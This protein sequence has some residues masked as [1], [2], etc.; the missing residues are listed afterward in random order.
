MKLKKLIV[1]NLWKIILGVFIVFLID[2]SYKYIKKTNFLFP[3]EID[4]ETDSIYPNSAVKIFGKTPSNNLICFD[5]KLSL[6]KWEKCYGIFNSFYIVIPKNE[7]DNISK[8]KI[9]T[10]SS[11]FNLCKK[12]FKPEIK[13]IR[14]LICLNLPV[15][16]ERFVSLNMVKRVWYVYS[17]FFSKIS[18]LGAIAL[19]LILFLFYLS[20]RIES[21][22]YFKLTILTTICYCLLLVIFVIYKG[23]IYH[24][25]SALYINFW[26]YRPMLY[27][28]YI[29][30]MTHIPGAY[31]LIP[32]FNICMA[33]IPFWALVQ[34]LIKKY[35]LNN[36]FL[37]VLI[38]VLS[39][40]Y[41]DSQLLTANFL[42]AESLSYPLFIFT[43]YYIIKMFEYD[44]SK[45]YIFRFILTFSL[46][47]FTRGQFAFIYPVICLIFLHL[48]IN[49]H[50]NKYIFLFSFIASIMLQQIMDRS[51]HWVVNNRFE[52][53]SLGCVVMSGAAL[54]VSKDSDTTGLYGNKK[55]IFKDISAYLN[56]NHLRMCFAESTKE[57]DIFIHYYDSFDPIIFGNSLTNSNKMIFLYKL[58]KQNKVII[59]KND[60]YLRV[61]AQNQPLLIFNGL[62]IKTNTSLLKLL[63]SD[64]YNKTNIYNFI[65]KKNNLSFVEANNLLFSL[66]IHSIIR[67]LKK[68]LL[69]AYY[70]LKCGHYSKYAHIEYLI[71][72][73]IFFISFITYRF[74][75]NKRTYLYIAIASLLHISNLTMVS[76]IVI[77]RLRYIF[78][79]K[80]LILLLLFIVAG[81]IFFYLN[82]YRKGFLK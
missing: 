78:Y 76:F 30:V 77:M 35:S 1:L 39:Y 6:Y 13:T 49:K 26:V 60:T 54:Y 82:E 62:K 33:I 34:L 21:K 51:Y 71:S 80:A 2:F 70:N 63:Y 11:E 4:I 15:K 74:R 14:H 75:E 3:I 79:T 5:E 81:K 20:K 25:D 66:S 53:T 40:P 65:N 32:F 28:L 16:D 38:M 45:K 29:N 52:S 7:I 42:I 22:K 41:I 27:P 50:P 72:I 43:C 12:H 9:N 58:M 23:A 57:K 67:N 46:L 19:I 56:K 64:K 24:P 59:E 18:L 73:I 10:S 37:P 36:L 61:Y 8:I 17:R 31:H 55:E 44:F 68:Y 48:I 69:L 47:I